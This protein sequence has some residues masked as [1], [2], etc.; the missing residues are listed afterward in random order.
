MKQIAIALCAS[1]FSVSVAGS[2][3]FVV[4][5]QKINP[6]MSPRSVGDAFGECANDAVC[7]T[8]VDG[9]ATY[10]GVP[11]GTVSAAL[12]SLPKADRAGEEGRYTIALP[13]GYQY[14]RSTIRTISVVPATGDRASVMGAKSTQR[15]VDV[16][17]WT[18]R[19]GLGG[20]R[21]WVEADYTI[22]GVKDSLA[23]RERQAGECRP[24]G[25]TLISCR[26]AKGTNKGQPSCGASSD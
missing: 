7:R 5:N 24:S 20:G 8:I 16:Y 21:S 9:A 13:D 6:V 25:S 3:D 1:V 18:P 14:C 15:G 4:V 23:D 17:T 19:Q 11:P 10:L 26:G 12:A 22:Y 2:Q